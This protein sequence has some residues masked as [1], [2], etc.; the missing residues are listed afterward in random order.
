P[1]AYD[2]TGETMLMAAVTSGELTAVEALLELGAEVDALETQY[3][4]TAL[5]I[6]ARLGHTDIARTLLEAGAAVDARTRVGPEPRWVLP[7]SRAGFGFGIGIIRGG[8]PADR[9]MRPFRSGG[10]TPLLYA[11]R[12]GHADMVALL[13]GA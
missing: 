12:E 10:L 3:E 7:N 2:S 5:M 4:Q 11:A 1:R 6:A 13:L 8:L 9:G